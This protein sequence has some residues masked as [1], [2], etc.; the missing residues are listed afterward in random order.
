MGGGWIDAK[1]RTA[2]D[3]SDE[4]AGDSEA[5]FLRLNLAPA[6][7]SFAHGIP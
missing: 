5:G 6:A 3:Q 4:V 1:K 7:L 2:Q